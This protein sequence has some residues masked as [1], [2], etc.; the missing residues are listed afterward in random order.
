MGCIYWKSRHILGLD[1]P[2]INNY[3]RFVGTFICAAIKAIPRGYPKQY[4][5]GWSDLCKNWYQGF[6]RNWK[7]EDLLTQFRCSLTR[8]MY[9]DLWMLNFKI[10][11][12]EAWS[13]LWKWEGSSKM[14]W[15]DTYFQ[16]TSLQCIHCLYLKLQGIHFIQDILN[17]K[18]MF[19]KWLEWYN[20][21][22]HHMDVQFPHRGNYKCTREHKGW[23]GT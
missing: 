16:P 9:G 22:A 21:N 23:V 19:F 15:Q 5:P 20:P 17:L 8:G 1:L 4:I 2:I 6:L 12:R 11:S 7:T 3:K 13:L 18:L 10:S 14:I